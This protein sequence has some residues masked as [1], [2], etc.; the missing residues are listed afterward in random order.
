VRLTVV[1]NEDAELYVLGADMQTVSYGV[2][3][4]E[5]VLPCG[6]YKL[7]AVR[8][9]ATKER[10]VEL[11][12]EPVTVELRIEAF[13]AIA[14]VAAALGPSAPAVEG[15]A[16][17]AIGAGEQ[18]TV[19]EGDPGQG[20][21]GLL[22]LGHMPAGD[23]GELDPLENIRLFP[24]RRHV[25]RRR[26][27]CEVGSERV[28]DEIWRG[29]YR[30][31][32]TGTYVLDLHDGV[33]WVRQAV[34]VIEGWETRVFLRRAARGAAPE[35]SIQMAEPKTE[36]VY[37]DEEGAADAGRAHRSDTVEVA[38]RALELGRP[39]IVSDRFIERLL[40]RKWRNP[41]MGLMGLHL[42]LEALERSEAP[43]DA[44]QRRRV[45]LSGRH[46]QDGAP[47]VREVI[48]NL[49]RLLVREGESYP[50]DL[51]GLETRAARFLEAPDRPRPVIDHPPMFWASW[52]ALRDAPEETARFDVQHRLW[53]VT[54]HCIA[55]G[56]YFAWKARHGSLSRYVETAMAAHVA[57][58]AATAV[59]T[60][61]APM[62][63]V[64]AVMALVPGILAVPRA[65]GV[66]GE[67]FP[68]AARRSAASKAERELPA[69]S[70][71]EVAKALGIPASVIKSL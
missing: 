30:R 48:G 61:A 58:M 27:E 45:D 63:P 55:S 9:G 28:G 17:R 32:A 68:L 51:A 5:Q 71:A 13:G 59:A 21:G 18:C 60:A 20:H 57:S 35:F 2:H 66:H 16:R 33:Q 8:G 4:I 47:V 22:I 49:R 24:W 67:L 34:L 39:A 41:V 25:E 38:R 52:I 70:K 31:C 3:R 50:A 1:G 64:G 40:Y 26:L 53:T 46:I 15:V 42:F 56:P 69:E 19:F 43:P 10:L 36:I 44:A 65:G 29:W 12:A 6:I 23:E 7:R 11:S 54:A 62:L 37:R 14:P